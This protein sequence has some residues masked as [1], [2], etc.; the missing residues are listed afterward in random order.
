METLGRYQ[1]GPPLGEGGSGRV[2]DA[3]LVGPGGFRKPVTLK[4]FRHCSRPDE[5]LAGCDQTPDTRP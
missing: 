1:L 3:V 2:Y 4:V 5:A